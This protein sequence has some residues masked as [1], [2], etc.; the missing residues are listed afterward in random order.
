MA[1]KTSTRGTPISSI[2]L[3]I[4][5]L[6]TGFIGGYAI[7]RQGAP[8]TPVTFNS[9]NQTANCP[10]ALDAADAPVLEGLIC[11]A[12]NCSDP[13]LTCHC[14]TAHQIQDQA[15]ALLA[16]GKTHEEARQAIVAQYFN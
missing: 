3:L 1:E 5:G 8:A 9:G 11:P 6:L 14:A 4:V 12:P 7:A 10:H 15:K 16:E 13:V 2:L